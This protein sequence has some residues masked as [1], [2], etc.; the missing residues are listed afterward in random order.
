MAENSLFLVP[1]S[2]YIFSLS[3]LMTFPSTSL[4]INKLPIETFFPGKAKHNQIPFFSF[5]MKVNS[6]FDFVPFYLEKV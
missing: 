1:K 4:K 3:L 5:E 2:I 6:I